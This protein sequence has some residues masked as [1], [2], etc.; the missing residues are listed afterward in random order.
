MAYPSRPLRKASFSQQEAQGNDLNTATLDAELNNLVACFDQLASRLESLTTPA[1]LLKGVS[2]ATAMSL[3]GVQVFTATAAQTIFTTTIPWDTAFT[4]LNV[5]VVSQG[6]KLNPSTVTVANASGF[7]RVTIPAQTLNNIVQVLA[8]TAGAG[9]LSRLASQSAGDGAT[10]VAI[11]DIGGYWTSA[12]VESALQEVGLRVTTLE[13]GD[14]TR[15]KKDGSN[16][17]A[18]GN[19]NLGTHQI[20]GLAPGTLNTDAVNLAQLTTITNEVSSLLRGACTVFGFTMQG[21]IDMDSNAIE[22]LPTPALD[23]D[24]ANKKYVDDA[25]AGGVP[26]LSGLLRRDGTNSPTAH[27]SWGGFKIKGLAAGA[28]PDDAVRVDQTITRDGLNYPLADTNWGGKKI[29]NLAAGALGTDAAR[30]DQLPSLANCL[31]LDGTNS[32]SADIPWNAKKITGLANG[33]TAQD[34][35]TV[36]QGVSAILGALQYD[37]TYATPD[38]YVNKSGTFLSGSEMGADANGSYT[39]RIR[40]TK[41]AQAAILHGYIAITQLSPDIDLVIETCVVRVRDGG[42]TVV[43]QGSTARVHSTVVHVDFGH[44]SALITDL[45][46]GDEYCISIV[47]QAGSTPRHYGYINI[48][49]VNYI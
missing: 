4:N 17:P 33:T 22:N 26:D 49:S 29:T 31:K 1:G 43:G 13:A 18:T 30:I 40:I 15:W 38:P 41:A 39:Q 46:V 9:V 6:L 19:W 5:S 35:A 23:G 45:R 20:K 27:V 36:A 34:A 16:G 42:F 8:Y 24:A 44:I 28:N 47:P 10:L 37:Y 12:E 7:L 25:V 11:R 2:A 32:P 3:V 21:G 48:H 14:N